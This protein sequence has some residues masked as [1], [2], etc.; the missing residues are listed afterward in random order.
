MQIVVKRKKTVVKNLRKV[1][2]AKSVPVEN[3]QILSTFYPE[4]LRRSPLPFSLLHLTF[5]IGV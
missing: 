2:A 5:L 4:H 1:T 3:N